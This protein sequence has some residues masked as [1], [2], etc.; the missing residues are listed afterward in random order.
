MCITQVPSAW[1]ADASAIRGSAGSWSAQRTISRGCARANRALTSSRSSSERSVWAI[2][3]LGRPPDGGKYRSGRVPGPSAVGRHAV[4]PG[5]EPRRYACGR[6][7]VQRDPDAA[8]VEERDP[9]RMSTHETIAPHGGALV[10]L[11]VPEGDRAKLEEE[12]RHFPKIVVN[13]RELS[14]LEMLSVG[15]LSP[16]TGFQGETDYASIL[17]TM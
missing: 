17:E 3:P 10:D 6:H 5:P 7:R 14:D 16:L 9:T 15:A 1:K 12:A 13:P 4:G 2:G 8:S 11:L